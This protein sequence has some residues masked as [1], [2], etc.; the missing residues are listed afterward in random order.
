LE[1]W[2]RT[3]PLSF[4]E[5]YLLGALFKAHR[6]SSFRSNPSSV[7]AANAALGS[8]DIGKAIAAAILTLGGKHA[9]LEQT[10]AFLSLEHP[11]LAVERLL[12]KKE[13][14]PG[15]GGSFQKDGI[16]P[17]WSDVDASLRKWYLQLSQKLEDVTKE[18]HRQGK[19]IYPNPSAFTATVAIALRVPAKLLVYLFIAA[20]LDAW[21]EIAYKQETE[22]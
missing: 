21:A 22:T 14:V 1:V 16:D 4:Q 2:W 17:F 5:Q 9:P 10:M 20:R 8:S 11:E 13:K 3:E 15:W 19:F 7:A 18:L 6:A 12:A